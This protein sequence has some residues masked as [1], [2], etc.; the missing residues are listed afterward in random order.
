L[1]WYSPIRWRGFIN[2][3]S[4]FNLAIEWNRNSRYSGEIGSSD[5]DDPFT[6]EEKIGKV[7]EPSESEEPFRSQP[8]RQQELDRERDY[9][10]ELGQDMYEEARTEYFESRLEGYSIWPGY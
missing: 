8:P 5:F 7:S 4:T 6:Q 3:S 1:I 10:E 2:P 9:S